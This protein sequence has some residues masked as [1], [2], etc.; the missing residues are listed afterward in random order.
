MTTPLR[1]AHE[2]SQEKLHLLDTN[3][4]F[5]AGINFSAVMYDAADMMHKR[6]KTILFRAINTHYRSWRY[7]TK[8][9]ASEDSEFG[10]NINFCCM[11]NDAWHKPQF[12]LQII[13]SFASDSCE[14]YRR[15]KETVAAPE[16]HFD[17]I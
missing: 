8:S 13:I 4:L 12:K 15:P 14:F 1:Q 11:G 16:C 10:L 6:V 2:T 7:A 3:L 5:I 9:G 17:Y